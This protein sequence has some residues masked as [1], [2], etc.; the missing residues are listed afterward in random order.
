L[1]RTQIEVQAIPAS[2][3]TTTTAATPV[4]ST[5][6][7]TPAPPV[8]TPTTSSA[9]PTVPLTASSALPAATPTATA[10]PA[11]PAIT[12]T[13]PNGATPPFWL[14]DAV[15]E[16]G[17]LA[18]PSEWASIVAGLLAL[19]RLLGFPS[20][21]VRG[22]ALVISCSVWLTSVL[23]GKSLIVSG[24]GRPSEIAAW[25]K[26]ARHPNAVPNI[27]DVASWRVSWRA[28]WISLQPASRMGEKLLREVDVGELWVETRKGSINGFFNVV[29]S[30][31]WWMQA[32]ASDEETSQFLITL[33]DVLWVLDRMLSCDPRKHDRGASDDGD[34]ENTAKRYVQSLI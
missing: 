28:W 31:S 2:S 16:L 29:V 11:L 12:P 7:T 15:S 4:S 25:T 19:D 23:Q 10:L 24:K 9:L 18:G 33:K 22:I 34:V 13:P 3:I 30:L 21:K 32:L 17:N 5:I 6:T 26:N 14:S 8:I 1:Y 27:V 20:G